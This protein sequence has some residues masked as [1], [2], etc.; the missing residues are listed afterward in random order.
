MLDLTDS[1]RTLAEVYFEATNV[2]ES[3]RTHSL[4]LAVAAMHGMD[5]LVT[6]NCRHIANGHVRRTVRDINDAR[7][8][9]TPVI[10]TPEELL[11][12]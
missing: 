11:E 10:C 5:Y 1:V 9:A 8:I 6:W 3:A 4:H 12:F 2:P 7:G